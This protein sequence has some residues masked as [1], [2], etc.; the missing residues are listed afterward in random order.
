MKKMKTAIVGCG[1][2]SDIYLKS[3]K[4]NFSVIDLAAC[5]DIDTQKMEEMAQKYQ[6]QPMKWQ[7]ILN[8]KE[9]EM[10]V[11]LTS[12][13]VHYTL[14]KEAIVAGKHVFSEK[15]LAVNFE[16]GKELCELAKKHHVRLA[17]APDT[18]LGGG[19]QTAL[20]AVTRGLAG[21]LLSGVVSLS[22]DYRIFG[23]ILPHLN[24][25]GGS[26]LFDMGC[27]Y[28]TALCSMLGP[29]ARISG[30]CKIVNPQRKGQRVG[31]N[32]F[33]SEF[34]IE[35]Y[36]V[37]TAL[38]EF[39]SGT[40]ITLHLNS[41]SILNENFYLELYGSRGILKMG[42]PNTFGGET[43]LQLAGSEPV[44]LPMT[45]GYQGQSRG[46]GAAE[47]AWSILA[48][49]PHR[50]GMEMALHVL[51]VIHGIDKS[52]KDGSIYMMTTAFN[53]PDPLPDGY[54]GVGFWGPTEESALV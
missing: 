19:I 53:K 48:D 38:L 37:V 46:I 42:D 10:I 15:M 5:S 45:H 29:V 2:I 9:I 43:L 24:K 12:P 26:V 49:R 8:D 52:A 27:Y 18:F 47:M 11:N 40:L 28:L 6:I 22:R 35:D 36:N 1:V 23:E 3:F 39:D 14:T 30:F 54:I 20:D 34:G 4:E 41:E 33:G 32:L 21:N 17:L 25:R 13:T 7:D 50:A 31:G 16:D 44:K 51:E